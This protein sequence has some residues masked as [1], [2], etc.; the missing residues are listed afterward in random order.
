MQAGLGL[1]AEWEQNLQVAQKAYSNQ[2]EN[3][4]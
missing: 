3:K 1:I 2:P 4:I